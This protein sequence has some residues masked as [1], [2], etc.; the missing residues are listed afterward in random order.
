MTFEA[1]SKF[2][3][4][5]FEFIKLFPNCENLELEQNVYGKDFL[6]FNISNTITAWELSGK[7]DLSV[8]ERNPDKLK[9]LFSITVNRTEKK[10]EAEVEEI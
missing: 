6:Q 1:L 10:I 3:N 7:Q 5:Y 9:T 8:L 2:I 4:A